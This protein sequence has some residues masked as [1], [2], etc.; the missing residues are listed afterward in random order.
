MKKRTFAVYTTKYNQTILKK[1][2][3]QNCWTFILLFAAT[4]G[5]SFGLTGLTLSALAFFEAT[6][7]AAFDRQLGALLIAVSFPLV[8][9]AA[10]ALDKWSES[11]AAKK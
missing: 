3:K 4:T 5:I 2:K 8:M 6:E 9:L 7:S 10:H 11:N 1:S